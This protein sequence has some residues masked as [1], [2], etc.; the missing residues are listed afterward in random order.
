MRVSS[1]IARIVRQHTQV[2]LQV[3]IFS[4][5]HF[6]IFSFVACD[7][8]P[9]EVY[10]QG[11]VQLRINTDWQT[12][13]GQTPERATYLIYKDEMLYT[14]IVNTDHV[15]YQDVIL[16]PGTYQL[17]VF[18]ETSDIDEFPSLR[19]ENLGDYRR[20]AVRAKP[21][22]TRASKA[23]DRDVTYMCD[24]LEPIGCA[25]DTIVVTQ[26]MVE[27]YF[28]FI[29]Y[30]KRH[31]VAR[32]DTARY[33]F[34]E[35]VQPMTTKLKVRILVRKG[36][37][38][39]VQNRATVD[40]A[41]ISGMADGF[42]LNRV[43]RTDETGILPLDEWQLLPIPGE[44]DRGWCV[45]NLD[46][47]RLTTADDSLGLG[48][49]T[50]GLPNGK[51]LEANRDSTDNVLTLAFAYAGTDNQGYRGKLLTYNVGKRMRYY[52][53]DGYFVPHGHA[54]E[55]AEVLKH[56]RCE[57]V[58]DGKDAVDIPDT[59]NVDPSN[60]SGFDAQVDDWEFGGTFEFGG[61]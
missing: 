57:I 23:W 55:K 24:P 28:R 51:E 44:T 36:F 58:I 54:R 26:E 11:T 53:Q 42:Y 21:R 35:I 25:I 40:G 3:L 2:L 31:D 13:F 19:F 12:D 39:L 45:F 17:I 60:A 48:I 22:T 16:E 47:Q 30:R 14:S 7:R 10:Y 49:D 18:N 46:P 15:E 43:D 9:L 20:A 27:E 50:Y 34:N 37:Q 52:V 1:T 4:F 32:Y 56:I 6:L 41:S 38:T 29:D 5:A 8:R 61:F 59:I 33:S